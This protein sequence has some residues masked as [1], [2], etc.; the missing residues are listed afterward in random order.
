MTVSTLWYTRCPVLT[1]SSVAIA[2]GWL[3]REFAPDGIEV[4]SLLHATAR[5]TRESH[6]SHHQPNSFRHGG[7]IPPL[8]ARANGGDTRVIGLT[9]SDTPY[10]V[11]AFPGSGIETPAHLAGKRLALPRRGNDSIDFARAMYLRSYELAL[12]SVGLA[13]EDVHIV[14]LPVAQAYLDDSA[15]ASHDGPL[16]NAAQLRGFQRTELLALIRGEVDAIP[17]SGY[18]GAEHVAA[19]GLRVIHDSRSADR[20]AQVNSGNPSILSVSGRLVEEHPD[21][22]TRWIGCL[23]KAAEWG[24]ANP[25]L[26]QR[27]AAREC[28]VAEAFVES[29]TREALD[30]H[31]EISLSDEHISA[32]ETQKRYLFGRGFIEKDFEINEWIAKEPLRDALRQARSEAASRA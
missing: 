27:V 8:W 21:L 7:N 30:A 6:F 13:L 28:G 32:L 2:H 15:R 3:E 1:A 23:L 16:W 4:L 10:Y 5:G 24:K 14:D 12:A 31:L 26:T 9:W 17:S 18:W 11:L 22:V 25:S 29:T 20:L 19:L